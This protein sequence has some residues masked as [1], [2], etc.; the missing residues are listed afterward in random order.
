MVAGYNAGKNFTIALAMILIAA[1]YDGHHV[2]VGVGGGT[3]THLQKTLLS[4]LFKLCTIGGI[5]Y[6]FNASE[7]V[8]RMGTIEFVILATERPELIYAYNFSIFIV[9]ELDE[10]T[11]EKAQAVF[12]ASQERT[13]V[14][15][16][17]G[18][19]PYSMFLTTAQGYKGTYAIIEELKE[20][21][22]SY[23]LIHAHS[24]DNKSAPKSWIRK[25]K[26]IYNE[27]QK[28]V[29]MDGAF[30]NIITGR[31]YYGYDEE[32][33]RL[34]VQPFTVEPNDLIRIGQ[35]FN[36]GY[37]R[38]V[39]VVKRS[40]KLYVVKGWEFGEIGHAPTMIR[41]SFPANEIEWYPDA[42]AAEIVAGYSKE[43][44]DNNIKV[45]IGTINPSV[46][47]RI[48]FVNKLFELGL[49]FLFPDMKDLA[50]ALKVR[51]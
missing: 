44:R 47:D 45:R 25:M 31:V 35:D 22:E 41:T 17:D 16:P 21:G 30:A 37:S 26:A 9:D 12:M 5:T 8:I 43:V 11:Q 18:R 28:R 6:S 46:I 2:R 32:K 3:I 38:G 24:E 29:F 23:Y 49:L 1:R 50:M 40:G 19:E 13:R 51:Q 20:K 14:R 10:L 15:L 34:K 33:C 39:A 42:S 4:E 48:F 27:I 7:H 36:A